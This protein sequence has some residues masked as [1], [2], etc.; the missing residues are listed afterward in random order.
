MSLVLQLVELRCELLFSCAHDV[1][2]ALLEPVVVLGE[3]VS[4][5][6]VNVAS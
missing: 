1:L 3:L 2:V 6:G 4:Q 5:F